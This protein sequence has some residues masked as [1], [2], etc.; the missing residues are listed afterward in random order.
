MG[1]TQNRVQDVQTQIRCTLRVAAVMT[2]GYVDST[3]INLTGYNGFTLYCTT[4]TPTPAETAKIKFLW[5]DD[6]VTY[7]PEQALFNPSAI[8]SNEIVQSPGNRCVLIDQS[9]VIGYIER[10][11]RMATWFRISV[12]GSGATTS[13][14]AAFIVPHIL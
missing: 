9:V 11:N 12:K 5:S 10:F 2:S 3:A 14:F 7:R 1:P 8:V 13:T 4:A 6:N